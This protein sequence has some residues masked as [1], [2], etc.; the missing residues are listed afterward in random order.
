MILKPPR[1]RG[2]NRSRKASAVEPVPRPSFM[3]S[4][5]YSSAFA[6]AARFKAGESGPDGAM[7]RLWRQPGEQGNAPASRGLF[8]R[9][10]FREISRLVDVGALGNRCIVGEQLDWERI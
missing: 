7:S 5:T 9:H 1:T 2:P 6:A 8:H 10:R 3:P 4:T